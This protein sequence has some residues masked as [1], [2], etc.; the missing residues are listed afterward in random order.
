MIVSLLQ[1]ATLAPACKRRQTFPSPEDAYDR[2]S[3]KPPFSE[4][5]RD[6]LEA[7]IEHGFDRKKD[8]SIRLKMHP[9]DEARVFQMKRL[10]GAFEMLPTLEGPIVVARGRERRVLKK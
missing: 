5:E 6:S 2:Y 8:G 3:S 4:L 10:E 9:D 1:N 7:Y